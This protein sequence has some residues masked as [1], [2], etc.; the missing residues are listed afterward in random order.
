MFTSAA[1]SLPFVV[2]TADQ[3]H[4]IDQNLQTRQVLREQEEE[5]QTLII[6]GILVEAFQRNGI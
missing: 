6:S 3:K 5:K 1:D 2:M 4:I